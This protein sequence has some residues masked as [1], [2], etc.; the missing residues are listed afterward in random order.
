VRS[1]V[2]CTLGYSVCS[3]L[4]ARRIS[5]PLPLTHTDDSSACVSGG[6]FACAQSQ[7][8]LL[9]IPVTAADGRVRHLTLL[10]G[11]QHSL[12]DVAL[13]FAG[14]IPIELPDALQGPY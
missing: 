9:S 6:V 5:S 1:G 11:D 8:V 13:N 7:K 10:Q 14:A 12:E 2:G 4:C 3:S